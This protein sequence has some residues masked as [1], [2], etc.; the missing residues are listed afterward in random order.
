MYDVI[1]KKKYGWINLPAAYKAATLAM[2]LNPAYLETRKTALVTVKTIKAMK[3]Q[4][5][6][7]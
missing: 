5:P 4:I 7:G 1:A 3:R 2:L 6:V